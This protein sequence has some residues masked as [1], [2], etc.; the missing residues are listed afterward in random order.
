MN[1]RKSIFIENKEIS[2]F[3]PVFIIAEAGVNH[4]GDMST[5]RKL[6]DI[7]C[8]AEVDAIKFQTFKTENLILTSVEKAP[9]QKKTTSSRESQYEMLKK[10]EVPAEQLV[11]LMDYCKEKGIIFLSTPFDEE[12]IDLLD[13]LGVSAFKVASTDTTNLPFLRKLALKGKPIILSTGMCYF[14]EV[15]KALMEM[16]TYND[17]IILLQCTANYPIRDEE[18]NLNVLNTFKNSFDIIIG[19]SD[20]TVGLG[21]SPYAI[22]MGARLVE[23]HFTISTED[24]GPDHKASLV[25]SQLKEYVREV[26]KVEKYL[27]THIKFPSF[28]ESKTRLSLQKCLVANREIQEGEV[29][30]IEN[31]VAKRTGGK[32]I[33]PI[34][35]KNLIG[36]KSSTTYKKDD[37]L[38]E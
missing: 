20:H 10:L 24:V 6:V 15:E 11:K 38:N 14:S 25:P 34:Y 1:F 33:S 5:A 30:T 9:Y 22:P 23:K 27:G 37:I 31:I 35:Y 13:E 4:N 26:R 2:Q 18:A 29:F 3:S 19:Y 12:S 32:G 8:E 17:Q 16:H 21:A 28:D 36:K 7:A